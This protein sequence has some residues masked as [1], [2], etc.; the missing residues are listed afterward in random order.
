MASLLASSSLPELASQELTKRAHST[1]WLSGLFL[2]SEKCFL[3]QILVGECDCFY[4]LGSCHAMVLGYSIRNDFTPLIK[5][6][7]FIYMIL[8]SAD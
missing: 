7:F 5:F 3:L 4:A 6:T 2:L 1:G 8:H